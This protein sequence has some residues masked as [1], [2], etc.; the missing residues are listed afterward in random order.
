MLGRRHTPC[1][2]APIAGGAG[3]A[4]PHAIAGITGTVNGVTDPTYTYD[5]NGNMTAGAGRTVTYTAFNMADTITQ[6]SASL[7]F[8]YSTDHE[9]IAL[10]RAGVSE[11]TYYLKDPISGVLTEKIVGTG[12]TT[13]KTYLHAEGRMIGVHVKLPDS[14]TSERY[15]VHDH[16]GSIAVIADDTGAVLERLSYDAW[17]KRRY[18][19]GADDTTN[20]LTSSET[21]G[22]T[23]HEM[24]DDVDLVHM[25]GRIY[26]P[27]I[28]RFMTADPVIED[29]LDAQILNHY[30]YVGNNPLS[31]TDPSGYFFKSLF[32]AIGKLFSAIG[33]HFRQ[34]LAIAVAFAFQQPWAIAAFGSSTA[35]AVIGGTIAGGIAGGN[36]KSAVIG[37]L[38]ALAFAGVHGLKSDLGFPTEYAKYSL[39]QRAASAGMHGAVGGLVSVAQGGEFGSGFLSAGFS[40]FAGG[41]VDSDNLAAGTATHAVL[42]GVGA[43][44]GGGK[45]ANGAVTG[46]FGYLYNHALHSSFLSAAE[47][48]KVAQQTG[49]QLLKSPNLFMKAAGAIMMLGGAALSLST[50]ETQAYLNHYTTEEG[51]RGIFA[52]GYIR[53]SP[54]GFVYLTSDLYISGAEA[55]HKLALSRT[56]DGYVAVPLRNIKISEPP[57]PVASWDIEPGGGTEIRVPHAVS[58]AGGYWTDIG[59]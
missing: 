27:V 22:F 15:F 12:G 38:T 21:R 55:R 35:A 3:N 1:S 13:W 50:K 42:G 10:T 14:S 25:N 6:G 4:R 31:F 51:Q 8:T 24:L 34:I 33:K 40:D 57:R 37:G 39:G 58:V 53:R 17:G 28:G 45:F 54:D 56:P 19:S 36:L 48:A 30:T 52:L 11:T 7:A 26:D 59:P 29:I 5:A 41:F 9:R 18:P 2:S 44:I 23:G 32:K 46:A 49:K 20:T 47:A 43:V 16:L